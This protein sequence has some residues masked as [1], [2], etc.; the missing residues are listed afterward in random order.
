M[1]R[2][3]R[4]TGMCGFRMGDRAATRRTAPSGSSPTAWREESEKRLTS[5]RTSRSRK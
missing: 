2:M 1:I 3:M 5:L 4:D